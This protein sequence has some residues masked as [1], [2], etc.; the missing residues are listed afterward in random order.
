VATNYILDPNATMPK[1]KRFELIQQEIDSLQQRISDET[2]ER[3]YAPPLHQQMAFRTLPL[4]E[5]TLRGLEDSSKK[6]FSTMT[7][8]QSACIPH[9]LAGRDILGA[10]R[11]GSGKTLAFVIPLLEKVVSRKVCAD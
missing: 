10:A 6:S 9:A 4:S 5:N 8:I 11:T 2:P 3:G 1:L 7:A